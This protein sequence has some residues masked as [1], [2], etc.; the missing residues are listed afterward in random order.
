M[1]GN[2]HSYFVEYIYYTHSHTHEQRAFIH[3]IQAMLKRHITATDVVYQ[4]SHRPHHHHHHHHYWWFLFEANNCHNNSIH[5]HRFKYILAFFSP[6][7]LSHFHCSRYF[8]L[9]VCVCV[10]FAF[11]FFLFSYLIRISHLL[12]SFNEHSNH[13]WIEILWSQ[14]KKIHFISPLAQSNYFK[15]R[16]RSFFILWY[17]RGIILFLLHIPCIFN[18]W[19]VQ[20]MYVGIKCKLQP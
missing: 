20:K 4:S 7:T 13:C 16:F 1:L 2:E 10:C 5:S 11:L 8:T 9:G 17:I 18:S 3:T 15:M 19:N 12:F 6:L 14:L